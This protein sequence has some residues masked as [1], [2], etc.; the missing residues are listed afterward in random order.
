MTEIKLRKK[1]NNIIFSAIGHSGDS[2]VCTSVSILCYQIAQIVQDAWGNKRLKSAPEIAINEGDVRIKCSPKQQAAYE[3]GIAFDV[4]MR[5][6]E[7]LQKNY[8][9]N[10]TIK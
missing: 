5:G 9:E 10:V 2:T 7:I 1:G 6:L 8:P 4:T 3:L